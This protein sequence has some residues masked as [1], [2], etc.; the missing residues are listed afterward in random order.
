MSTTLLYFCEKMVIGA[1][2]FLESLINTKI[3]Q[4]VCKEWH[5]FLKLLPSMTWPQLLN[6]YTKSVQLHIDDSNQKYIFHENCIQIRTILSNIRYLTIVNIMNGANIIQ[7][8]TWKA[9]V[10]YLNLNLLYLLKKITPKFFN[11]IMVM[12]NYDA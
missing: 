12:K 6:W 2:L 7:I 5:K 4:I 1:V 10:S 11:N 9:I 3:A 8:N